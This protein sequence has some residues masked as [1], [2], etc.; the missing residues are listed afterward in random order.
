MTHEQLVNWVLCA[1][2]YVTQTG[3]LAVVPET[4]QHFCGL[5]AKPHQ[6]GWPRT[7]VMQIDSRR[8]LGGTEITTYDSLDV[9]LGQARN[10]LYLAVKTWA[11]YRALERLLGA[12]AAGEQA[13]RCVATIRS[14]V[15][16]DGTI[17]AVFEKGN[18]SMI[19]PAIEG[20]VFPMFTGTKLDPELVAVLRRTS[21]RCWCPARAC[22]RTVRGRCLRPATTRGSVR[23]TSVSSFTG[24]CWGW[25]GTR[26]GRG[27]TRRMLTG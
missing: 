4:A 12:P 20:L 10:N 19:I 14:M 2:V 18:E 3:D 9:S 21:R 8:C 13:Q 25:R 7:G 1:S 6:S 11:A 16:A 17:P 23:F 27:P 5:S 22:S 26:P 15:R 24:R